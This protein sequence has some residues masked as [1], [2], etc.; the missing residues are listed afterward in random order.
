M[1]RK[2]TMKLI[3]LA[4]LHSEHFQF[5]GASERIDGLCFGSE[6]FPS[7]EDERLHPMGG[8]SV[9]RHFCGAN[10]Q[11]CILGHVLP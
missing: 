11:G 8:C 2:V 4:D 1:A 10:S 3:K 9:L 6:Q 7:L 5:C